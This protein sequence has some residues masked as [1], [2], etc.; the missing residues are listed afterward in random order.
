M[1]VRRATPDDVG[2]IQIVAEASWETDYP[3]VTRERLA[4][5]VHEWYRTETLERELAN[6]SALL[7]VAGRDLPVGFVHVRADFDRNEGSILRLY[8]H[9]E[10]RSR[11]VGRALFAE[12]V[13]ELVDRGVTRVRATTL[14]QN[15][16][17]NEFYRRL[18]LD[19]VDAGWTTV[20]GQWYRENTYLLEDAATALATTASST[21]A[22][23]L[24]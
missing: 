19:R 15:P 21:T 11:G 2:A 14:A 20:G 22:R 6:P 24:S 9:P 10:H 18:G 12:A 17:G 4:A 5:G 8:V 7:L 16:R 1:T 23:S 13:A 3:F